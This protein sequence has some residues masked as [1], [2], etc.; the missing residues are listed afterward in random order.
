LKFSANVDEALENLFFL[1]KP[2]YLSAVDAV[3]EAF[4]DIAAHER[5]LLLAM[6]LALSEY[7]E[8]LDPD[9]IEQNSNSGGK[10]G[11]ILGASNAT[12][13]WQRYT[14]LYTALARQPPG[15]MPQGF[16]EIFA[17]AYERVLERYASTQNRPASAGP[18]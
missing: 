11:A 6:S 3:R 13:Y 14:A 12:K 1:D 2:E 7:L 17:Q 4:D 8:K 9:E 15:Q 10:R 18:S 5:A 16:L